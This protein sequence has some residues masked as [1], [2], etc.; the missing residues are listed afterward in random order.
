MAW[1]VDKVVFDKTKVLEDHLNGLEDSGW[2]I[3]EIEI[4]KS[5][6]YDEAIVIST[7]S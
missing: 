7:K 4:S 5:I 2:K 3:Y 1:K 6:L